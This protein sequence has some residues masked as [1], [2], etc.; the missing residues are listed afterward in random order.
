A[1]H[2]TFSS[3]FLAGLNLD[4]MFVDNGGACVGAIFTVTCDLGTVDPGD[5]N[6]VNVMIGLVAQDIGADMQFDHH[7]S[8]Q[9][10]T[11][12]P[13]AANNEVTV[14]STV[15]AQGSDLSIQKH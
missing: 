1:E 10:S 11:P 6:Q 9:A 5:A 3:E 12:D 14:T 15:L 7:A 13:D 4:S 2:T 8:V